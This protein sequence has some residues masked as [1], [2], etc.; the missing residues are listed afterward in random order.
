MRKIKFRGIN[1]TTGE[2]I[3]SVTA[4][5]LITTQKGGHFAG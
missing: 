1:N 2:K 5:N 3:C 4:L